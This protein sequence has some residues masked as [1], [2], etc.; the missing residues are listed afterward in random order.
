[1]NDPLRTLLH[2]TS[3]YFKTSFFHIVVLTT[4]FSLFRAVITCSLA[5]FSASRFCNN[6]SMT[7]NKTS[8]N[9]V[10][11][12]M[13]MPSASPLFL[14]FSVVLRV[15][16]FSLL[17][18]RKCFFCSWI[19]DGWLCYAVHVFIVQRISMDNVTLRNPEIFSIFCLN[20][21]AK[22]FCILC[23]HRVGLHHHLSFFW[24]MLFIHAEFFSWAIFRLKL[25]VFISPYS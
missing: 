11:R 25:L 13:L 9:I 14:P 5:S 1:M 20:Y 17:P 4:G 7:F 24:N 18:S 2:D 19:V 10:F 3:G 21:G 16:C 6:Q 8:L 23:H 15:I 22:L 12:I